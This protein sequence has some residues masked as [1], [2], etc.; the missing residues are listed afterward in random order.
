MVVDLIFD[1]RKGSLA[2]GL[3][4]YTCLTPLVFGSWPCCAFEQVT[5]PLCTSFSLAN[6]GTHLPG[7]W[8]WL[9]PAYNWLDCAWHIVGISKCWWCL[10]LVKGGKLWW[11]MV[12]Q[13][14]TCNGY[15]RYPNYMPGILLINLCVLFHLLPQQLCKVGTINASL[16]AE[17]TEAQRGGTCPSSPSR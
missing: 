11:Q 12:V 7:M 3:G 6:N 10:L 8:Q 1:N 16:I 2:Q 9:N 15:H 13:R 14:A 5:Q 4:T 17:G